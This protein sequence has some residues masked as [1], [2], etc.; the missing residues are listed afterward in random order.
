[1]NGERVLFATQFDQ[2][3]WSPI[4]GIKSCPRAPPHGRR[5]MLRRRFLG[6]FDEVDDRL[7]LIAA[8][9]QVLLTLVG[10]ASEETGLDL[11]VKANTVKHRTVSILSQG[12]M[13]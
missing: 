7:L 5:W 8:L 11:S 10:A 12:W 13:R 2:W 4:G 1:M 6:D 3:F 9:A